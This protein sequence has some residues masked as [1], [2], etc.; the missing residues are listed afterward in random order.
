MAAGA[1]YSMIG[2]DAVTPLE[3]AK[4]NKMN[5]V[6]EILKPR[7]VFQELRNAYR[8][9]ILDNTACGCREKYDFRQVLKIDYRDNT[10]SPTVYRQILNSIL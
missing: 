4:M 8:A 5:G 9:C 2:V 3:Y 1:D 6:A 7:R 10:F